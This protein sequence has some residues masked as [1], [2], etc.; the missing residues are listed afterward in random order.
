MTAPR[1]TKSA[2]EDNLSTVT[3]VPGTSRVSSSERPVVRADKE[4]G[5]YELLAE[6]A[7]GGM[8]I[9]YK[10]R[11]KGLTRIV[12][13]K[14]ILAGKLANA[15]DVKRFRI[16]AEAAAQL[17]HANIV[18]IYD[19][20]E[21]EGQPYF[22][23]EYVKGTSLQQRVDKEVLPSRLA[24]HYVEQV[25]RALFYAHQKG[26][27]HRDL[28]PA[29]ILV[30]ESDRP[31]LTDFGL[32]K[33]L[34]AAEAA[35]NK[36]N[37]DQPT[38]TGT[39][40]GTPSY[41]APEQAGGLNKELSPACDIYG[42]GAVLYELISGRPPFKAES[43]LETIMQ[44][45]HQDPLPPRL[46]N[47]N[48]DV[49]LETICMKCLEKDPRLRYATA[50]ALADDLHRY[51]QNEAISA[52]SIN[53]LE[54][55][56]RTLS[57]SEHDK[58]FR[59]WGEGLIGLG[60]IIFIAHL[61]TSLLLRSE[62]RE[63]IAF[64]GPRS[65]ML[66]GILIGLLRYRPHSLFL[67]TSSAERVVWAVW[68]GYLLGFGSIFWVT[69]TLER[70]SEHPH[71]M[72]YGPATVLSGMA[73]FVMGAHIWGGCYVIG[74]IFMLLAPLLTYFAGSDWSPLWFGTIWA[75]ALFVL[76]VRYLYLA[77]AVDEVAAR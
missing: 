64:W 7:R 8:G 57:R 60:L 31:K 58:E 54:R 22:S 49:D 73:F 32:A 16:E 62:Y 29:N 1:G 28:K 59:H 69:T 76:G 70:G 77:K 66:I 40:L 13:L 24:A 39:V 50:E 10:A 74:I 17:Q 65:L 15:D 46:L 18:A 3:H 35:Q 27:L 4:F 30:D 68:L 11:Q 6:I 75:S 34:A 43:S 55:L 61:C 38:R 41:M 21:V 44:V 14:M 12:A 53:I 19:V 47:R 67:P 20:G 63:P 36:D 23:M 71:L 51:L 42:L 45:L 48:I 2:N 9:V 5:N 26:I 52:R 33:V 72:V 56:G 37:P 25:A